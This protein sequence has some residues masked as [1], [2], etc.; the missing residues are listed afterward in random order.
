MEITITWIKTLY[1]NITACAGNNGNYS[2]YFTLSRSIRQGCPIS[3]F[4]FLLMVE[5]LAN[6]I[7]NYPTIKGIKINDDIFKLAMM[8]DYITL[9]NTDIN[10]ITN[11]IKIF[12][13]FER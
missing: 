9:M 1:T 3:V 2:E 4:L 10:S 13:N 12:N 5:I 7:R 11:T 8:A 6:K